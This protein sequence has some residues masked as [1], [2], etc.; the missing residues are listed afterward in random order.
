MPDDGK[1]LYVAFV[2]EE[3]GDRRILFSSQRDAVTNLLDQAAGKPGHI[4]NLGHGVLP[5]TPVDQVKRLVD[6]VHAETSA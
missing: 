2:T 6:F 4:F 5:Q 3:S 1:T